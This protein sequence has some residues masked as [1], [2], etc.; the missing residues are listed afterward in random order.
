LYD[1]TSVQI[2]GKAKF[3]ICC[4]D[5]DESGRSSARA[6]R[7]NK[8]IR[9]RQDNEALE[10]TIVSM[11]KVAEASDIFLIAGHVSFHSVYF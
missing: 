1:T 5:N 3:Q 4:D 2:G 11:T 6:K 10:K 7:R 9:A 8:E